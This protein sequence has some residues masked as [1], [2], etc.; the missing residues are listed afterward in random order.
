MICK[1]CLEERNVLD[2]EIANTIKGKIYRR[3]K[4][5]FCKQKN[6]NR[7]RKTL[8]LRLDKLKRSLSCVRCGFSDYRALEFH[9][10]DATIKDFNI[11]DACRMGLS[12]EKILEEISKCETLCAN[13]HRIEHYRE[14]A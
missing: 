12:F 2:F 7:R 4:C 14:V 9:H 10:T 11:A 5:K 6:Q 8:R 3:R 1:Y 13:C